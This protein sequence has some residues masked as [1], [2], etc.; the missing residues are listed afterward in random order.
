MLTVEAFESQLH[1]CG[2][3]FL[4]SLSMC[5]D[6]SHPDGTHAPDPEVTLLAEAN[7]LTGSIPDNFDATSHLR[8]FVAWNND[9]TGPIPSTLGLV[10]NLEVSSF[11][12]VPC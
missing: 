4:S 8:V 7:K 1:S 3:K 2:V 12:Y 5:P 10:P 6:L 11:E 9:L